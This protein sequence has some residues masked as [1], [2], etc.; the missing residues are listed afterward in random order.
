MSNKKHYAFRILR[1][2]LAD[3]VHKKRLKLR[4]K[5]K[6]WLVQNKDAASK[7]VERNQK[8]KNFFKPVT[9]AF[10]KVVFNAPCLV[11]YNRNKTA[12]NSFF[13]ADCFTKHIGKDFFYFFANCK[14]FL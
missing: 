7:T 4:V 3:F 14:I 10:L 2:S 8:R 9:F 11:Y 5:M 1:N 6:F 12:F 13:K